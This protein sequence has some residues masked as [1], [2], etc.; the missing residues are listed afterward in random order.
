MAPLTMLRLVALT[1]AFGLSAA[2]PKCPK[3]IVRDV[4]IIGGGASGAHAA[5]RLREDF[6]KSVVVVET[7]DRLVRIA[8]NMIARYPRSPSLWRLPAQFNPQVLLTPR[9]AA[10]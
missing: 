5:V 2:K 10:M 3:T 1:L 6:D 4:A 8:L 7:K 9:R